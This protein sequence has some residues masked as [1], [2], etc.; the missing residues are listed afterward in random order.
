[1]KLKFDETGLVAGGIRCRFATRK[2]LDSPKTENVFD[3][4]DWMGKQFLELQ[5]HAKDVGKKGERTEGFIW[6]GETVY[7]FAQ[8]FAS[9]STYFVSYHHPKL[10]RI[11][12]FFT[13]PETFETTH[14]DEIIDQNY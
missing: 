1:M 6:L 4:V 9:R 7:P 13:M 5:I 12:G 14:L 3:L 11:Q 8:I 10:I 2:T